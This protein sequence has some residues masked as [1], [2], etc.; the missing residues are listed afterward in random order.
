MENQVD[1]FLNQPRHYKCP[2]F[3]CIFYRSIRFM[4]EN[5]IQ[6]LSGEMIHRLTNTHQPLVLG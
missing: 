2:K 3:P 1:A 4:Q 5:P 6:Y